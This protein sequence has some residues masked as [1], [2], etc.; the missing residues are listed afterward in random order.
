MF[1]FLLSDWSNPDVLRKD[2]ARRFA[3]L[4]AQSLEKIQDIDL[5]IRT[6]DPV[7]SLMRWRK[8]GPFERVDRTS[9]FG[10]Q[11]VS[12][13]ATYF[14]FLNKQQFHYAHQK[15]AAEFG[16]LG[17]LP[18]EMPVEVEWTDGY[19]AWRAPLVEQ[20][21]FRTPPLI[22]MHRIQFVATDILW[23]L[24][25]LVANSNGVQVE[26]DGDDPV[27]RIQHPGVDGSYVNEVVT[28]TL[29]AE[30]GYVIR[31]IDVTAL[32]EGWR[33]VYEGSD[34]FRLS[35]IGCWI[36]GSTKS[37]SGS[38]L[39]GQFQSTRVVEER[40]TIYDTASNDSL[41]FRFP[42]RCRVKVLLKP[43]WMGVSS[44]DPTCDVEIY[45]NGQVEQVVKAEDYKEFIAAKLGVS[46]ETLDR[47]QVEETTQATNSNAPPGLLSISTTIILIFVVSI[48]ILIWIRVK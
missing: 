15:P 8:S 47:S 41:N 18:A 37:V 34:F 6:D 2:D 27:L 31:K 3:T 19:E 20:A 32:K 29:S 21:A 35:E 1:L 44:Q 33:T 24:E 17:E 46:P 5:L 39:G 7:A 14:D 45:Q 9:K 30:H 4:N 26:F 23:S 22:L 40:I 43:V 13:N 25:E 38:I 10:D 12:V 16:D 42:D 11:I 48:A 28:V 36:P